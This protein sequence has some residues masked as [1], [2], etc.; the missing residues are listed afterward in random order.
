MLSDCSASCS[1]VMT[2][3]YKLLLDQPETLFPCPENHV[4]SKDEQSVKR[5]KHPKL[6]KSH[7]IDKT[8]LQEQHYDWND[9]PN[10]ANEVKELLGTTREVV[11]DFYNNSEDSLLPPER[12][13]CGTGNKTAQLM[14]RLTMTL[15]T[16]KRLHPRGSKFDFI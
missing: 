8:A 1:Y 7:R 5:A 9:E 13:A 2:H 4:L 12:T 6:V 15:K 14:R 3:Q 16:V 11:N 10:R